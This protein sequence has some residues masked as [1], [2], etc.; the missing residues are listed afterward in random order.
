V[1][2]HRSSSKALGNLRS[3]TVTEA[4]AVDARVAGIRS[5]GKRV[6]SDTRLP[7]A[8]V[9]LGRPGAVQ[10]LR[11]RLASFADIG[12]GNLSAGADNDAA[13]CTEFVR[14]LGL[15]GHRTLLC[16]RYAALSARS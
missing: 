10:L 5:I 11:V 3:N 6:I 12:T 13:C 1:H 8:A 4:A 15:R 14:L 7:R 2:Q 16:Q 9:A